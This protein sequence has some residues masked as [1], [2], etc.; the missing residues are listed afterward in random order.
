MKKNTMF[1][2]LCVFFGY[3]FAKAQ[4]EQLARN[5]ANQGE[6][7]KAIISY[8]K[9]L[10]KQRGNSTLIEGLI[11]SY[12]QLEQYDLASEELQQQLKNSRYK[13]LL[14]VET[15]YNEELRG[16]DSLARVYYDQAIQGVRDGR[17]QTTRVAR[18]FQ[19]HNLLDEAV[20]T[21][22]AAMVANPN[23]N[24]SLP[25]ARLYGE[26]GEVEKMFDSCLDLI[27]KNPD[28]ISATQ[29]T[30]S[31]YI[32]ND[33][34]NNANIIFRKTLLRRLQKEPK[35]VFNGLLSWLFVQQEQYNKAFVQEKAIY[36]RTDGSYDGLV[37]LADIAIEEEAYEDAQAILIF[38]KENIVNEDI[39]LEAE[40][41]LIQIDVKQASTP[42]EK[43]S[44]K[45]RFET[46]LSTPNML[47][48][49]VP[50]QVDYAHFIAFN[51]ENPDEAITYLKE[52][53]TRPRGRFDEA[54]LKMELAD[55][56]V[57]KEKFNQALIYYSQ[58]Q[59]K[60]KN[61]VISQEARF[62]VA[63]TSYYK[64]DFD[65]A[66]QQLDVLKKGSTQ[67]IA[68][69]ALELL[70]VIRDNTVDDSLQTAL[71]KYAKADLLAYQSK[72]ED[73]ITLYEQI[74]TDHKGEKL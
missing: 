54:R 32:T 9:A 36:K 71:K 56:L 28:Y 59:N 41:K 61:N 72:P 57:L 6:Y 63:K 8:K 15:G 30:F 40:Q 70:L 53:I 16:N 73:A 52:K 24:Y 46:L 62:K 64:G 5:Y 47:D 66:E 38:L 39:K 26:L 20:A 51:M 7:E 2:I 29:R 67:L 25:L 49:I 42:E 58:I 18:T 45:T 33:P 11:K 48:Y 12:Q 10:E 37:D 65:W 68:N 74:L 44:I 22:E 17:M 13:G 21:F 50:V 60:I 23:S 19:G 14:I 35:V 1:A 34:E 69:D 4:S 43:E 55:I 27:S 3:A 31:E